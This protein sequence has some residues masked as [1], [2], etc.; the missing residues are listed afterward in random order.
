MKPRDWPKG[1]EAPLNVGGGGDG[2]PENRRP[3]LLVPDAALF[4]LSEIRKELSRFLAVGN[5]S[6][7]NG[8]HS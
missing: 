4:A 3:G 2:Q 1:L 7:E 6:C 5:T 8:G